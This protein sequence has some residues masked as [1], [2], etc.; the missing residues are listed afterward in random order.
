MASFLR[1]PFAVSSA[2][3]Q[4]PKFSSNTARFIHNAPFKPQPI[5]PFGAS[6][7]ILNKSR[8][9]FQNAFRRT[10]Q[11]YNYNTAQGGNLTQKLVYGGAIVGGTILATNLIFNRETREDGGMPQYEQSYLN[12]TFMHTGLGVGIIGVAA[13]ALHVNGWS[14]RLMAMNPWAILGLGLVGS[15]GTMFGTFY[16]PPEK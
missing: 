8:Q 4:V 3:H 7:S 13:R 15:I 6:S 5:K 10:Y 16:T 1:R 14:V 12:E 11:T 9:T 2:L